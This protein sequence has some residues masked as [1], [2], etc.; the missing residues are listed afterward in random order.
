[1]VIHLLEAFFG[2]IFHTAV[3]Q[4][5]KFQLSTEQYFRGS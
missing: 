4:L 2:A 5:T 3:Q 1:M